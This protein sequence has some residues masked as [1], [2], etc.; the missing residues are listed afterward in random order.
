VALV[1]SS[2]VVSELDFVT[3]C[4]RGILTRGSKGWIQFI[5]L[6]L[7]FVIAGLLNRSEFA[8]NN[9]LVDL[10][11]AWS[12]MHTAMR[13]CLTHLFA[14]FKGKCQEVEDTRTQRQGHNAGKLVLLPVCLLT[15]TT[16]VV[17]GLALGTFVSALLVA[18]ARCTRMF[19]HGWR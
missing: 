15:D 13:V 8:D 3:A 6:S 9:F 19:S 14:Q 7:Q 10:D 1:Q 4:E 2:N 11:G 17:G 5:L 16:A 12:E 18:G